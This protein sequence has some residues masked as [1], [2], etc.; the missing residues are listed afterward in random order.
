MKIFLTGANGFIGRHLTQHLAAAGHE[1]ITLVRPGVAVDIPGSARLVRGD[2]AGVESWQDELAACDALIHLAARY[3]IGNVDRAEMAASNIEGT[4]RVLH[5]AWRGGVGRI[6]HV[7]STAALGETFGRLGDES[8]RHNGRFRSFYEQ[9]KHVAHGL[10]EV[11]KGRGV[12]LMIAI[13]GGVF[14]S[15]DGSD[16]AQALG[17]FVQGRLP[18][19][20]ASGSR[21]QLCSVEA[22]CDGLRRVVEQGVCGRDYLLT[23]QTVGMEQL[24]TRAAQICHLPT[25]RTVTPEQLRWPARLCDALRP[26]GLRLPLSRETLRVM[27]GSTYLYSSARAEAELGWPWQQVCDEFDSRFDAY[28]RSLRTAG[29]RV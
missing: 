24:I 10:A 9:T 8:Q 17:Q 21:F 29:N 16:L 22:L 6:V 27:D 23:G 14:G 15:G 11:L 12:P 1:I 7:S 2:L 28:V 3:R 4:R 26:L 18:A 5:A 19:Q 25:P 13:P 20:V